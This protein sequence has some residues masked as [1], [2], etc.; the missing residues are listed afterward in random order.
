[1]DFKNEVPDTVKYGRITD[2]FVALIAA[3]KPGDAVAHFLESRG[4]PRPVMQRIKKSPDWKEM[5]R[6]AHTLV[7][8]FEVLGG[9]TVPVEV[10]KAIAMPTQVMDGEKSFDFIHATADRLEKHIPGAQ[11]KTL[12]D[13]TH[14]VSP[15]A[16]APVLNEFFG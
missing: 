14:E 1:L 7:Y 5:E 3:G 16:L 4:T 9:G 12:K 11:R 10:A 8:D 2:H 13:Q 6:I 15:E